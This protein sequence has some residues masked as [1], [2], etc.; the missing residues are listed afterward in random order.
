M[1]RRV[2]GLDA[3]GGR[4]GGSVHIDV[5]SPSWRMG[6]R[7]G[8]AW[9]SRVF[10]RTGPTVGVA[11]MATALGFSAPP[12]LR[13][14]AAEPTVLSQARILLDARMP[15]T[16]ASLLAR[17]LSTGEVEGDQAVLLAARAYADQRSWATARRLLVGR[18]FDRPEAKR[19]ATLLLAQTYSGLDSTSRAIDLYLAVLADSEA[20]PPLIVR[21]GL[22]RAYGRVD[23]WDSAA[24]QLR[25]AATEHPA[26]ARWVQLSRLQALAS[27]ADTAAFA[28]ADSLDRSGSVPADSALLPAARLAFETGDPERGT[29]IARSA[30]DGVWEILAARHVAPHLWASGDTAGAAAAFRTALESGRHTV[31]TGPALLELDRSW[32]SL[33]AVARSDLSASR[34]ARA[35]GYL[36]EALALAPAGEARG[37]IET[38]ARAHLALGAPRQAAELLDRWTAPE[39]TASAPSSLWVLAA[40]IFNA[41][42]QTSE[43]DRAYERAARRSGGSAALA[44]YLVAD[45]HQDAGRYAEATEAFDH[46]YRSFPG[47]RYGSRSLERL[48][49]LAFHEGRFDDADSSLAEYRERYPRGSWATGALYWSGRTAEAKGDSA[50]AQTLYQ[51]TVG[52]DPLTY[53]AI[54]AAERTSQDRWAVLSLRP[55]EPLPDLHPV[56]A[57]TLDRMNLLRDLGWVGRARYEYREGRDRGPSASAQVLAFAHALNENGWTQEGIR[58]G[59]RAKARRSGW[60]RSVLRAIYPLPFRMALTNAAHARD[61]PPHF[62]AGLSRRESMFD[63]EIM[64]AAN[65]VGLMQLLPRTAR[66]VSSRAGLPEYRRSQLTVPQVNLLLG[67]QYLADVLERFDGSPVAGMISYNAGPHR[68]TRWREFREFQHAEQLVERIPFRETREYVRAVSELTEIY[69]YLYPSLEPLTP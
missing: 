32:R 33:R 52:R 11:V 37:L 41:L 3:T 66:D 54:L 67:T 39:S 12:A 35:R 27:A 59:W 34:N 46:A 65:A 57:E 56:Y 25:L 1:V 64:S 17:A 29:R 22:A 24:E 40:R 58:Q 23:R 53:Y 9:C 2:R 7:A 6:G 20:A 48:A 50:A 28:L 13:A 15:V 21:T 62:V 30:D 42:G 49:L 51:A 44:A 19:A 18:T 60:T 14:Q 63:P 31:A 61:L 10:R 8:L 36:E 68:Y 55:D 38:L 43:A 26:V 47:S 69:R 4:R 5:N 16:A 45:A